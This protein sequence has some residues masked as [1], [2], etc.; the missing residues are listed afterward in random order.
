MRR[1][2][3][4]ALAAYLPVSWHSLPHRGPGDDAGH[5]DDPSP[6]PCRLPEKFAAAAKGH[7]NI[8]VI[9]KL[10]PN[11][12]PDYRLG[13]NFVYEHANHSWIVDHDSDSY[14]LYL[15]RKGMAT[16]S[17]A[18]PLASMMRAAFSESRSPCRIPVLVGQSL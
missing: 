5:R 2:L 6:D 10:P 7:S 3:L 8:V 4:L 13:Y 12:S 9:A 15:D 16:S 17:A 14:K 11:L 1:F 18:E